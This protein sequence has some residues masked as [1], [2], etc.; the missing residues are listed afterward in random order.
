LLPSSL[1]F[2]SW[3]NCDAQCLWY[4]PSFF[5]YPLSWSSYPSQGLWFSLVLLTWCNCPLQGSKLMLKLL[6]VPCLHEESLLI[7]LPCLCRCTCFLLFWTVCDYQGIWFPMDYL[8]PSLY[9]FYTLIGLTYPLLTPH[10][11]FLNSVYFHYSWPYIGTAFLRK[12]ILRLFWPYAISSVTFDV[13]SLSLWP[14]TY[15]ISPGSFWLIFC[16][17]FL[18]PW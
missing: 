15:R 5:S 14:L 12:L 7:F 6:F 2:L 13:I 17:P 10:F 8:G 16:F 18:L 4:L 11:F 3:I 9:P 1:F